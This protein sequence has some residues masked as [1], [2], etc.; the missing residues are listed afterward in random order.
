M[1][2]LSEGQKCSAIWTNMASR[3]Q[4]IINAGMTKDWGK[5]VLNLGQALG[6]MSYSVCENW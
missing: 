3:V 1:L 4:Q 6:D 5:G 2:C